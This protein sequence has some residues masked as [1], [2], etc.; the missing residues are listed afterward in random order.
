MEFEVITLFRH[1]QLGP[2]LCLRLVVGSYINRARNY[3]P[4]IPHESQNCLSSC[5]VGDVGTKLKLRQRMHGMK[6]MLQID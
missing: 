4:G 1:L 2:S 5:I 3:F 6:R